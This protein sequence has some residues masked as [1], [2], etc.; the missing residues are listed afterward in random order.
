MLY[1]I[2][3]NMLYKILTNILYNGHINRQVVGRN[4]ENVNIR[5]ISCNIDSLLVLLDRVTYIIFLI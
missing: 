1:K 2:L 5:S 3:T 4:I